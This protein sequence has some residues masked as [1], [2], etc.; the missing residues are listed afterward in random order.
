MHCTETV[1]AATKAPQ[2]FLTPKNYILLHTM[3]ELTGANILHNLLL[4][5]LQNGP[6]PIGVPYPVPQ[7]IA[8]DQ[9]TSGEQ[10]YI[11]L[12]LEDTP[13]SAAFEAAPGVT[14]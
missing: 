3:T 9:T 10:A 13:R 11:E 12:T 7:F 8:E 1:L 6:P 5:D 14:H 4:A 2:F